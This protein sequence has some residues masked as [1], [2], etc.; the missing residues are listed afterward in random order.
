MLG[1]YLA[2]VSPNGAGGVPAPD[3]N[4]A[5]WNLI[6]SILV[7]CHEYARRINSDERQQRATVSHTPMV[8]DSARRDDAEVSP[9][10]ILEEHA[11]RIGLR[12]A[13]CGEQLEYADLEVV[14]KQNRTMRVDYCCEKCGQTRTIDVT[15]VELLGNDAD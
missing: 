7:A 8:D 15:A 6:E 9:G 1:E 2:S 10:P 13:A 5:Y 4:P 11:T 14:S 12:C 3:D